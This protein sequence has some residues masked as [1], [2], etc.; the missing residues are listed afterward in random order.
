MVSLAVLQPP[1]QKKGCRQL[2]VITAPS[3]WPAGAMVE[4]DAATH[5][6]PFARRAVND[7]RRS[8]TV[9]GA[10]FFAR[11][12]ASLRVAPEDGQRQ[13]PPLNG[14]VIGSF[15]MSPP[16]ALK[17][18]GVVSSEQDASEETDRS[19]VT[20]PDP[21][22]SEGSM[23]PVCYVCL[24]S[25]GEMLVNVCACRWSR[26]HIACLERMQKASKDGLCGVCKTP[27]THTLDATASTLLWKREPV[28]N[29]WRVVLAA[30]TL[31]F[32]AMAVF[33]NSPPM[34]VDAS[35]DGLA[36]MIRLMIGGVIV[37]QAAASLNLLLG[38]VDRKDMP[39]RPSLRSVGVSCRALLHRWCRS[40]VQ[41]CIACWK[42]IE[43]TQ[44]QSLGLPATTTTPQSPV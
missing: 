16:L 21:A 20:T 33:T 8:H 23:E 28:A 36:I 37:V 22:P 7:Q 2:I 29:V 42:V 6:S 13:H 27:W 18:H 17:R 24:A 39:R 12:S 34:C 14:G 31:L 19:A 4:I 3:A 38:S 32:G 40:V 43:D 1:R 10:C 26:V 5:L 41:A 30:F 15:A 35:N 44:R 11:N 9:H 25:E